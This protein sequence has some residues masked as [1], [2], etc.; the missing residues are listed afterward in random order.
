MLRQ[1]RAP[2]PTLSP[3]HLTLAR[4]LS[5]SRTS[6][7]TPS[8][9]TP[10]VSGT[11][12]MSPPP[13]HEAED[14][15]N[16]HNSDNH[17]H[18]RKH[19]RRKTRKLYN[20]RDGS[21]GARPPQRS[22]RSGPQTANS[23]GSDSEFGAAEL[24][25]GNDAGSNAPLLRNLDPPSPRNH[26]HRP[27]SNTVYG[28]VHIQTSPTLISSV[29]T[30]DEPDSPAVNALR[31]LTF[32][33]PARSNSQ[34]LQ[35]VS[36]ALANTL[37]LFRPTPTVSFAAA[38]S[39]KASKKAEEISR[40]S[41]AHS[42][43]L[44]YRDIKRRQSTFKAGG[45]VLRTLE[46]PAT[47][48]LRK[49]SNVYAA[50]PIKTSMGA[51]LIRE[52]EYER[53]ADAPRSELLAFYSTPGLG[54][55]PSPS[56]LPSPESTEASRSLREQ[57]TLTFEEESQSFRKRS[58]SISQF[59]DISNARR[60]SM[61]AEAA[62]TF[63]DVHVAPGSFATGPKSRKQSLLPAEFNRRISTVQFRSRNS[64]HE[65]IWRE[66]ETTS[67]S[68]L[69]ASSGA[70]QYAGHSFGS[71]PSPESGSSPTRD[72]AIKP[73]ETTALLPTVPESVSIFT[74]MPDNL[75]RWTWGA[76]SASIEG[77]PR[78][79]DPK[80]DN[81]GQLAEATAR[82]ADTQGDP[83]AQ[84]LVNSTLNPG[85]PNMHQSSDQQSSRSRRPS[86]SE[87][88]SVQSFPP[89]LPR[90]STAEW[91]KAPLVDLNDPSAGRASRYQIKEITPPWGLGIDAGSSSGVKGRKERQSSPLH[92]TAGARSSMMNPHANARLGSVASPGSGIGTSSRKRVL[93]RHKLSTQA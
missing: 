30:V 90:S 7:P 25:D 16:V 83:L 6:T 22:L 33:V 15:M 40:R 73:K 36:T 58:Q 28:G 21:E 65:V 79:V 72:P 5:H 8:L 4:S 13:Q 76:S 46:T 56:D 75:L 11:P 60:C 50:S 78:P 26:V 20:T 45:D 9:L 62:L 24:S 23:M 55:G 66:D 64:V 86:L 82:S 48:T 29:T 2:A 92:D 43:S 3:Q 71:T 67:D 35:R 49:A 57:P 84:V 1:R 37:S 93:L 88:P 31:S 69:T 39:H 10:P 47:I 85:S 63:A 74:K 42:Q 12:N 61:P 87:L 52:Q 68:S 70:S 18:K 51:S 32:Q 77:T 81:I 89:L 14:Y 27:Q 54:K 53:A 91:Q 38:P 59:N 44:A 41:S 17:H 80:A 19:P 34:G